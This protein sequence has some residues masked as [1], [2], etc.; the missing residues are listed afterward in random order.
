VVVGDPAAGIVTWHIDF[1]AECY[2]GSL[3]LCGRPPQ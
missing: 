1:L 2:S 3:V